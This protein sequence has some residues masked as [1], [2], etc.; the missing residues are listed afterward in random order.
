MR[1]YLDTEFNGFGGQL[2]SMAIVPH[3][4]GNGDGIYIIVTC[5]DEIEDWVAQNVKPIARSVP[6]DVPVHLCDIEEVPHVLAAYFEDRGVPYIITDWP[7][8]VRYFCQAVITG[9]GEMAAIP[10]LQFDVER[11]DAYPTDLPGAI[12]H[13]AWWDA[14]A[15]RHL[16]RKSA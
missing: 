11:V 3:E 4:G 14:M 6:S 15:L 12:Q 10:R 5:D 16:L 9:P 2:L 7:D 8:D 13:N 1:Y